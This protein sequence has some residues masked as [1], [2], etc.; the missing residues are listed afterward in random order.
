MISEIVLWERLAAALDQCRNALQQPLSQSA[1]SRLFA[2]VED[3]VP[4]NWISAR[5]LCIGGKAN[6]TLWIIANRVRQEQGKGAIVFPGFH[7]PGR[8]IVF[9]A[10]EAAAAMTRK[11]SQ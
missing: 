5:S 3:P 7:H 9:D 10:V 4:A 1:R 2:A 11:A 8:L 6:T